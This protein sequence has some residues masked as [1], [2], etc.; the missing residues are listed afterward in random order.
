MTE[1]NDYTSEATGSG[2]LGVDL[3]PHV[4]G[5]PVRGASGGMP[6]AGWTVV[7]IAVLLALLWLFG[8]K[9][10]KSVRM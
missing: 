4:T 5:N 1:P 8:G 9:I 6:T 2:D 3:T 7:I 10:F